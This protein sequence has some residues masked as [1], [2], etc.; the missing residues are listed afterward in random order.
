MVNKEPSDKIKSY[1]QVILDD[2]WTNVY[3]IV[4]HL[5]EKIVV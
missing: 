3:T 1:F 4:K 2:Q 5:T